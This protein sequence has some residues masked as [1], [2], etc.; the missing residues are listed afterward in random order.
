MKLPQTRNVLLRACIGLG[1][2]VGVIAPGVCAPNILL[3]ADVSRNNQVRL[4]AYNVMPIHKLSADD[5]TE[6]LNG[7]EK[8]DCRDYGRRSF[9]SGAVSSKVVAESAQSISLELRASAAA[10]GGHYRICATCVTDKRH[11]VGIFPNDTTA[12]SSVSSHV[13]VALTLSEGL[14]DSSIRLFVNSSGEGAR[15]SITE[16]DATPIPLRDDGKA[17]TTIRAVKG[18]VHY[19]D[20][21]VPSSATN[22]GGCCTETQD[23]VVRIDLRWYRAPQLF[24]K[25]T[26]EPY[27]VGGKQTTGFAAVGAL[28]IDGDL[29][30]SASVVGKRTILT[31]AHCLW[32]RNEERSDIRF[33]LGPNIT[34]PQI[35]RSIEK[36]DYP[37]LNEPGPF[38]YND[39]TK[40]DDIALVY[41]ESD[42]ETEPVILADNTFNWSDVINKVSLTF[43]GYGYDKIGG[44][45]EGIGVKREASWMVSEEENRRVLF[46]VPRK[47]TCKGDSGGP[48][49]YYDDTDPENKRRIQVALT[50]EGGGNCSYGVQ[51]KIDPYIEWIRRRV[52]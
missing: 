5:L 23:K 3:E 43:V 26:L 10:A 18:G 13:R 7:A 35:T 33:I 17:Y 50:S 15:I 47:A 16:G 49:F 22:G 4:S 29:L 45:I 9:S 8:S 21:D 40:E 52:R 11:C 30:C 41:L 12:A 38:Q 24:D 6:A 20:I 28:T 34:E 31:A 44:E 37:G 32:S 42:L 1:A 39:A 14:T 51:T 19:V 27:I 36:W 48:T 46:Y 2:V 25:R